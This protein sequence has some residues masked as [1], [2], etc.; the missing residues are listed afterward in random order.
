MSKNQMDRNVLV[1]Y[2][3]AIVAVISFFLPWVDADF[4]GSA[5][6]FQTFMFLLIIFWSPAIYTALTKKLVGIN[7]QKELQFILNRAGG[8]CAIIGGMSFILFKAC[9]STPLGSGCFV[10]VGVYV[11]MFAAG[12][13]TVSNYLLIKKHS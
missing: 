3:S 1:L 2:L 9:I 13:L 12:A 5:N 7:M 4:L 11:F 10:G 8:V 6:G